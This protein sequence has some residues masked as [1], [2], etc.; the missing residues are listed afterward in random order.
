VQEIIEQQLLIR[1][2]VFAT[3]FTIDNV[4]TGHKKSCCVGHML[5]RTALPGACFF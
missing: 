2:E 5:C 4:L 1:D 3:S